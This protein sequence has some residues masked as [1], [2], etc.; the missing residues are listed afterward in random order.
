VDQTGPPQPGA[1][2]PWS[3]LGWAAFLACS[4]T[5]CIGMFL[6]VLLLRDFGN[7]GFAVFAACNVAGAAAMGW[8]VRDA[9][10]SRRLV[11][12]HSGAMT[13]FSAV[14]VLYHAFFAGWMLGEW[15]APLLAWIGAVVLAALLPAVIGS[16]RLSALRV[17]A[18]VILLVTGGLAMWAGATYE[19]FNPGERVWQM[20]RDAR[21]PGPDAVFLAA[22]CVLGFGLCP[23][24][25]LTFHRARR[26]TTRGAGRAAFTLGFGVLFLGL[27]L[28]TAGYSGYF[29]HGHRELRWLVLAHVIIQSAYTVGLHLREIVGTTEVDHSA[30][31]CLL[32]PVALLVLIFTGPL[33]T[34]TGRESVTAVASV[35]GGMSA[36]ELVYR[37][38]LAFYGLLFPAYVWLIMIPTRD[39]HSGCGG[40]AGRAKLR[41]LAL[42]VA[43]A[44][45]MFALGFLWRHTAWL[46]PGVASVLLAR[47][48]LPG[49]TG[50]ARAGAGAAD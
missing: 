29:L 24:L 22:S 46:G 19:R 42:T 27:I 8:V 49:G 11:V 47:L 25:D 50:G 26:A 3:V 7:W 41:L 38:F 44:A 21:L 40:A 15:I 34:L 17:L 32:L 33:M 20:I 23:Y 35:A 18:V 6:P 45:P 10:A 13:A 16:L 30:W 28:L 5:W 43:V 4:W 1:G 37:G 36:G 39:G 9:E 14:T 31:G 12:K 2:T 48:M